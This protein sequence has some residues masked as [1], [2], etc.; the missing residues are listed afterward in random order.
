MTKQLAIKQFTLV[1]VVLAT[2]FVSNL[3]IAY[4]HHDLGPPLTS[5]CPICAASHAL[6]SGDHSFPTSAFSPACY[7]VTIQRPF[8]KSISYHPVYLAHLN[9]RAPPQASAI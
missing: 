2:F 1:L 3:L 5:I 9:N 8:E 4:D 6:S 7:A